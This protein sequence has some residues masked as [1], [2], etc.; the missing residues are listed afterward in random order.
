VSSAVDRQAPGPFCFNTVLASW[1]AKILET[2][3][4]E[5]DQPLGD[6]PR[7]TSA[8]ARRVELNKE[9]ETE[10]ETFEIHCLVDQL[11]QVSMRRSSPE[12]SRIRDLQSTKSNGPAGDDD[13]S[14]IT[15]SWEYELKPAR[16]PHPSISAPCRLR[17]ERRLSICMTSLYPD[18]RSLLADFPRTVVFWRGCFRS[19]LDLEQCR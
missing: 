17:A 19:A 15:W 3:S 13:G 2:P 4:D 8:E 9:T 14:E 10:T 1:L 16:S 11:H 5:L 12:A 7:R 18:W 6:A